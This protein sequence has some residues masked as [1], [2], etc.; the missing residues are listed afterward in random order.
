MP[1]IKRTT[2]YYNYATWNSV[3]G[4]GSLVGYPN[5]HS[6]DGDASG[7]VGQ[8]LPI[9][10]L[11]PILG[12]AVTLYLLFIIIVLMYIISVYINL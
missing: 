2:N 8:F 6:V 5:L 1:S 9:L 10:P 11:L 12:E 4:G 7:E 3:G